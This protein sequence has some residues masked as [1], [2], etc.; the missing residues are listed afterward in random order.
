MAYVNIASLTT[1]NGVL[2]A[3]SGIPTTGTIVLSAPPSNH[4]YK[5]NNI[6]VSNRNAN[7]IFCTIGLIRSSTNYFVIANQ[8][9]IPANASIVVVG[10][11]NPFYLYDVTGDTLSAVAGTSNSLDTFISYEDI[12]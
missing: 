4:T 2:C 8:I 11:D 7:P 3:Y 6:M 5:L 10:K 1:I 12:F 9:V